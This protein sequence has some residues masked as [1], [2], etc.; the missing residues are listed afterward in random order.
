M[1][2]LELLNANANFSKKLFPMINNIIKTINIIDMENNDNLDKTSIVK[3]Q[4]T[5]AF[6][7]CKKYTCKINYDSR[8]LIKK[9]Y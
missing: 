4:T 5:C 7:W 3:K 9:V 1:E 2:T 8:Y 6:S